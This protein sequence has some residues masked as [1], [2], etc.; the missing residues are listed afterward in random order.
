MYSLNVSSHKKPK[1]STRKENKDV[2]CFG[3]VL[4]DI[5]PTGKVPG[6]APMNVAY[7]LHQHHISTA[8]VTRIGNDEPGADLKQWFTGRG[9]DT[10]FFQ[11][12]P[13]YP[14]GK[15][16]AVPDEMHN[17]H[18]EIAMPVAWDFISPEKN[19][20]PVVQQADYFV[21][22]S[23]AS[24]NSV[25]RDTLLSLLD[26]AAVK[27]MDVNLR[28]PH[29]TQATL[30]E[31]MSK[32]DV[33]KLNHEELRMVSGWM[34]RSATIKD[35]IRALSD[36]LTIPFI[37]VT[38]GASGALIYVNGQF[39]EHPGY[40]VQVEDTIGSGDAFLAGMLIKLMADKSPAEALDY[41][42]RLGA[43]VASRKGGCPVYDMAEISQ[44]EF[45]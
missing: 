34:A 17:M 28:P 24:R 23:L 19:I 42:V 25:S 30:V 12:D 43:F 1:M 5:L 15:V 29:F 32:A 31:L 3:E 10:R 41:A 20:Q 45:D 37:I 18:Y 14:T 44:L 36:Q 27:V 38:R 33:L 8:I 35:S 2:V 16:I 11:V 40:Y 26:F 4:W 22:G 6:G 39:Y 13:D 7:H 21:F 9:M